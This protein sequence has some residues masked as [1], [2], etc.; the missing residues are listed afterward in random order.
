MSSSSSAAQPTSGSSLFTESDWGEEVRIHLRGVNKTFPS[1]GSGEP[2]QALQDINQ[3]IAINETVALVG[4][5]GCGKT[6][7]LNVVAG[8]E[9][10]DTGMVQIN[11]SPITGPGP[12]RAVVFQ[13]PTLFPWLTV[14][15]NVTLGP[16]KRGVPK[17]EYE[18]PARD[19]LREVALAGF[20]NHYPY[21]LSGGMQ[22]RVQIARAMLGDPD[23]L[24][25]DEPFGALDYQTRL[26]MQELLMKLATKHEQSILLITHDVPEAI[27]VADRVVV[28]KQRPGRIKL[29]RRVQ[30]PKP[31]DYR[32]F[33]SQEYLELEPVIMDA[34]REEVEGKG[35]ANGI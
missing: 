9:Q 2:V 4:P 34:I 8:F 1:V 27:F 30:A 26:T 6:T 28:M 16:R 13:S 3:S 35:H 12:D 20:E 24:L 14:W 31:R 32:F 18:G 15:K 29:E 7:L 23:V 21:Q 25:M 17:A 11:A 19:L 22:Q 33:N 5:S 10:P